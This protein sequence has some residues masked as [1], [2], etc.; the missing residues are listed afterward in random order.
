MACSAKRDA[1]ATPALS[2]E[3]LI[4]LTRTSLY[5]TWLQG[6][7]VLVILAAV[8]AGFSGDWSRIGILTADQ[9]AQL[10]GLLALL[11]FFHIGTSP[12]LLPHNPHT[13]TK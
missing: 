6:A 12:L 9:E 4:P 3:A 1:D 11:G 10:R 13:F 2:L 5:R 7:V 8:D